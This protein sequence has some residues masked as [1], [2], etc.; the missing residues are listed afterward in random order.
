MK[1]SMA[2]LMLVVVWFACAT[3][4][5]MWLFHFDAATFWEFCATF[6][7]GWSGRPWK[8]QTPVG[9][10]SLGAMARGICCIAGFIVLVLSA[11]AGVATSFIGDC[12]PQPESER[13][14]YG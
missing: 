14:E 9:A 1:F 6:S 8:S 5:A 3:W 2:K 12:S 7:D 11:I 10:H 13:S 4:F